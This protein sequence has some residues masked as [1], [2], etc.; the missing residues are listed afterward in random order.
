[1]KNFRVWLQ[2][3]YIY[4]TRLFSVCVCLVVFKGPIQRF[5][6]CELK[7]G[8]LRASFWGVRGHPT[9]TKILRYVPIRSHFL[10]FEIRVSGNCWFSVSR[11]SKWIKLKIKTI[12]QIKSR[13]WEMK[14]GKYTKTLAKI[15]VEGIIRIRDIRRSVLPKFIELSIQRHAGAH[16]DE[17]QHGG[18]KPTETSVTEFCYQSVNLFFEKLINIKVI[19]FL[20]HELFR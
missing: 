4:Q 3:T 14:G 9:P 7:K 16:P 8:G 10:H 19:L 2:V 11:H 15:W 1:M 6:P 18:R 17:L 20:I 12:R 13:I 5:Q